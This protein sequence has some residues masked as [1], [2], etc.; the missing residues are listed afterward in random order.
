MI[1]QRFYEQLCADVLPV[2]R[3]MSKNERFAITLG[4]SHG[5]GLSDRSS[6]FDFRVYYEQAVDGPQ[7]NAAFADLNR[8]I[9]KWKAL[10]VEID[11]VWPRGIAEVDRQLDE[12]LTGKAAPVPMFWNI[13]GYNML[14]DIC[15]QAIVE[16]PCGIAQGWK[17]RL[18]IYPDALSDSIISRHAFSLR[19]WRNDYHYRNKVVRKDRV[20]CASITSRLMNDVMQVLYALNRFYFPGDG[21]NL[22]FVKQFSVKLEGMENRVAGILYP[23]GEPDGLERQYQGMLRLIDDVLALPGMDKNR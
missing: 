20:F 9:E 7:W 13:W 4:G 8:F 22:I 18:G 19:Y 17:D 16:D 5:K 14:T 10:D 21:M 1:E 6:D 2:F 15:N 23:C 3:S 11:G 12:W